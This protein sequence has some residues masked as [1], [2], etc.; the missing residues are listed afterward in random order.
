MT[1][2][3]ILPAGDSAVCAEFGREI[4]PEINR[5]VTALKK[6]LEKKNLPGISEM[7]PYAFNTLSSADSSF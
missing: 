5:K 6:A 2:I 4:S 1:N 3:K 7:V